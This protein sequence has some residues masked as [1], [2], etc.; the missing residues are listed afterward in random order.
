MY[1]VTSN[2]LFN[3]QQTA[4]LVMRNEMGLHLWKNGPRFCYIV[5][6]RLEGDT[7]MLFL[8]FYLVFYGMGLL[9]A[10]RKLK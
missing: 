5:I 7:A 10:L 4:S 3:R 6:K 9:T 8:D 2:L 1:Q